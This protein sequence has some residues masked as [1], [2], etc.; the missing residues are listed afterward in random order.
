MKISKIFAVCA[1]V[2]AVALIY[3]QPVQA[4]VV[5]TAEAISSSSDMGSCGGGCSKPKPAPEPDDQCGK[6][7]PAPEPDDQCGKP[8]PNPEPDAMCGGSGCG[9]GKDK[10]KT[11][12]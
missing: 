5:D 1:V 8:K 10:D 4:S 6:P 7:K 9:G 2:F 12:A 3:A 11:A